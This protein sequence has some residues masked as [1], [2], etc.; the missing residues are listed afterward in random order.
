MARALGRHS[1]PVIIIH[2][3]GE[4]EPSQRFLLFPT[5]MRDNI[6]KAS[7]VFITQ[8]TKADS[9]LFPNTNNCLISS[10]RIQF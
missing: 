2:G 5:T 6:C 1:V 8:L 4:K 3:P 7:P 10:C 9:R